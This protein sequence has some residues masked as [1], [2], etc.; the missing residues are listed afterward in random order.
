[1]SLWHDGADKK[2]GNPPQD[3]PNTSN[4]RFTLHKQY[5]LSP[6][7]LQM[8]LN[9]ASVNFHFGHCTEIL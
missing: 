9:S 2:R 5:R 4:Q 1:M 7:A 6:A 3:C 8:Q